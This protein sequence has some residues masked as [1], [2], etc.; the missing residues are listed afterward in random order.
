MASSDVVGPRSPERKF[1][2]W[3][4]WLVARWYRVSITSK[5]SV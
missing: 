3:G 2:R 1:A 5:V 4:A